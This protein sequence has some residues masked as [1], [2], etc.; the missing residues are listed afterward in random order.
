MNP[1][2]IFIPVL[3]H[4]LLIFALFIKLG[5]AK[6]KAL[7]LGEVN[8]K[9]TALNTKAWPDYVVK[10]SNN[11][12]NQFESPI[13]FYLLSLIFYLTNNVNATIMSLMSLYV[14]SRYLHSY[15]HVTSNYVPLRFKSFLV[16]VLT[17]LGLTIWLLMLIIQSL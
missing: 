6:S 9:E 15:F 13:L 3:I 1:N 5:Q 16:G 7:S 2:L 17:L 11:I 12:A 4:M 8:H 14:A 10:V